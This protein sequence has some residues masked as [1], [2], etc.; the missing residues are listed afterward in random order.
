MTLTN[1]MPFVCLFAPGL[2]FC[3]LGCCILME[4]YCDKDATWKGKVCAWF[5][6]GAGLMVSIGVFFAS[7]SVIICQANITQVKSEPLFERVLLVTEH[8]SF[9]VPIDR[10]YDYTEYNKTRTRERVS[11][12]VGDTLVVVMQRLN[13]TRGYFVIKKEKSGEKSTDRR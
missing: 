10:V 12:D 6:F 2:V 7:G 11:P 3:F 5:V 13:D 9:I 4:V 1:I 8:R